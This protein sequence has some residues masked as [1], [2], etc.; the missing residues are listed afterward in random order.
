MTSE[1][2]ETEVRERRLSLYPVVEIFDSIQ[3]EGTHAGSYATF[4]RLAG[5]NVGR[6][7]Q[8][9]V[10]CTALGGREFVCDTNFYLSTL[11]TAQ[12]IV[13]RCGKHVCITGGEP[14]LYDLGPL[15]KLLFRDNPQ[16]RVNVETNGTQPI[17]EFPVPVWVT[18]SPK[19]GFIDTPEQLSRVNEFKFLVWD[20]ADISIAEKVQQRLDHLGLPAPIFLQPINEVD[21]IR[22]DA[23]PTILQALRR[24]P[25][26]RISVQIHKALGVQ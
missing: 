14:L 6:R 25:Q 10:I 20:E 2:T 13:M 8:G 1:L 24:H 26:W 15:L 9:K 22:T 16:R 23:V 17:P 7:E 5:C 19:E 3:G 21:S 18:C 12:A 11:K 4:V